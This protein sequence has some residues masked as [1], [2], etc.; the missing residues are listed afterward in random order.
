M[1]G[2]L[3]GLHNGIT[4]LGRS[5]KL[6]TFF[7]ASLVVMLRTLAVLPSLISYVLVRRRNTLTFPSYSLAYLIALLF[8]YLITR[9][10]LGPN[11]FAMRSEVDVL[12]DAKFTGSV[13]ENGG[14]RPHFHNIGNRC[15]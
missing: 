14:V 10:K 13:W 7:Y 11:F 2:H 3:W 8:S 1:S 4:S 9:T 6:A 5:L 15:M 12:N